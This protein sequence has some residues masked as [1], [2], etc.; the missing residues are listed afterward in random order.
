MTWTPSEFLVGFPGGPQVRHGYVYQ[1]LGMYICSTASRKIPPEWALTHLNSGHLIVLIKGFV[2]TAF[3]VATQ[4]ADCADWSFSGVDGWRN[5]DPEFPQKI[6]A[7]V[8]RNSKKGRIRAPQGS[9]H[10]EIAS[11][12]SRQREGMDT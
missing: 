4:I 8:R 9:Q 1:G 10:H 11:Q 12:I 7:I 5:Q 2:M 3:P 6:I